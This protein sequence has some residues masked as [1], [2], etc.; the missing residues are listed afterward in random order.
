MLRL[1]P[2]LCHLER[3]SVGRPAAFQGAVLHLG[4]SR[5][6]N[7]VDGEWRWSFARRQ[8]IPDHSQP[9]RT[10]LKRWRF[11]T[12]LGSVF[13]HAILLPDGDPDPHNH[14]FSRSIS[15]ILRGGYR[16]V[17]GMHGEDVRSFAPVS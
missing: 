11:D 16:E 10:Y 8:F 3:E 13:L 17:R 1:G 7:R 15:L 4:M 2:P 12:P 5:R 14:P 9:G 6:P